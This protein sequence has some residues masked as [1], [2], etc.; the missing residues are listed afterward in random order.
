M[1]LVHVDCRFKIV[2]NKLI[3]FYILHYFCF[4][5]H[6]I[7]EFCLSSGIMEEIKKWNADALELFVALLSTKESE[8]Q[9]RIGDVKSKLQTI[10]TMIHELSKQSQSGEDIGEII[11]REL[12]T[13]DKA[14]EEAASRIEVRNNFVFFLR[15][16]QKFQCNFEFNS[17]VGNVIE[18]KSI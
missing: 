8:V 3:N 13:M 5:P 18:I 10:T 2:S 1:A 11:E 9:N 4:S 15:L 14:I 17:I 6:D 12:S 16:F 7:H